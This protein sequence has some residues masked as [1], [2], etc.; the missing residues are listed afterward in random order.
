LIILYSGA[1][2]WLFSLFSTTLCVGA[3]AACHDVHAA[4]AAH[5]EEMTWEEHDALMRERTLAFP[6]QTA[7]VGGVELEPEILPDGTKQWEL[8]AK[9]V[10]WEVE[11]GRVVQAMTYNGMVPG[12]TLRGEDGDRVRVILRNELP[13]S[14]AIHFH[15]LVTPNAMDGVPDITQPPVAPGETFVYEFTLRGPAVGMYH[16][17]HH[18]QIQVPGG[19]AGTFLVGQVPLPDGVEVTQ[20]IPM[21]VNDAGPIGYSING[22]SFPATAPVVARQGEHILV[23]YMNEGLQIHPM[24]LHGIPQLVVA[25]DGFPLPQPMWMDTVNVAPGERWSVLIEADLPGV[26][27]W[28]CHILT[29]ADRKD[30][31]F[32]MVTALIVE[33]ADG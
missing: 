9:I 8:M 6:A 11:P 24:H 13:E 18:A 26:W 31:M 12:P 4:H 10:D 25:K 19:M 22:K 20:E 7:G 5:E 2:P 16:S 29:H 21:H 27:A 32:G 33:E 1:G 23:H 30:G 14:T 17:H 15:G 3:A 28:H